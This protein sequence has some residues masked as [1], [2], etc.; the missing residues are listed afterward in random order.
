MKK[1]RKGHCLIEIKLWIGSVRGVN[2]NETEIRA[3][4]SEDCEETERKKFHQNK[5]GG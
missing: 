4:R 5:V 1:K 3:E 2:S